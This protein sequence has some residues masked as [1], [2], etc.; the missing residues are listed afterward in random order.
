VRAIKI[1]GDIF[2]AIS[3]S[4]IQTTRKHEPFNPRDAALP[5][6]SWEEIVFNM[7]VNRSG[8]DVINGV[9]SAKPPHPIWE[10]V[11]VP[12]HASGLDPLAPEAALALKLMAEDPKRWTRRFHVMRIQT[13]DRVQSPDI[14]DVRV[15]G[16]IINSK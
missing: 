3:I 2:P 11:I 4:G 1:N 15:E 7:A 9:F 8:L 16:T 10:L 5:A 12:V 13:S 14:V 6:A